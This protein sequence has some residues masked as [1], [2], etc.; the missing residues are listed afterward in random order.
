MSPRT[1][2]SLEKYLARTWRPD[3]E[4]IDGELL[5]RNLGEFDHADLQSAL[6]AWLR[7]RRRKWAVS[8]VIEQRVQVSATHFRVPDVAVLSLD[9]PREQVITHPP[10]ICIDVLSKRDT[11]RSVRQRVA[12]YAAMGVKNIWLFE[13]EERKVWVCTADSMTKVT[14]GVLTAVGTEVSIPLDE[15]WAD[16][17]RRHL[18]TPA[19]ARVASTTAGRRAPNSHNKATAARPAAV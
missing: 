11:F 9:Y 14:S 15:I 1:F 8:V 4:Y 10:L 12:D 7:E 18:V 13:P 6:C 17:D 16:L 19:V 5:R 3:R 2:V